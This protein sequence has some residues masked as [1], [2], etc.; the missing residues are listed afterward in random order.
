MKYIQHIL[1]TG[2]I[3]LSALVPATAH[4]A[5]E[6][7]QNNIGFV[8]SSNEPDY[9]FIAELGGVY[10]VDFSDSCHES[11]YKPQNGTRT[12]NGQ[13]ITFKTTCTN[14][15][16]AYQAATEAGRIWLGKEFAKATTVTVQG[17]RVYSAIGFSKVF[18]TMH[19][20]ANS[21]L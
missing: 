13:A 12:Y 20:N 21:A 10:E 8:I 2:L 1:A 17:G 3:C 5:W 14:G 6:I 7:N 9:A 15:N 19:E 11:T 4:A 16:V 18:I